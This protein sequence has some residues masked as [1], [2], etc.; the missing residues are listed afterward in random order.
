MA[1]WRKSADKPAAEPAERGGTSP[2]SSSEPTEK[3]AAESGPKTAEK[4]AERPAEKPAE[5]QAEK[6]AEKQAAES[7]PKTAEKPAEKSADKPAEK[8]AEKPAEKPAKKSSAPPAAEAKTGGKS[9][10]ARNAGEVVVAGANA[11]R[12]RIASLLWL[13]AVICA[14]FLAIGALMIALKANKDN[15]IVSFILGGA[16]TL[17]LG[18]FSRKQ[19]IFTFNGSGAAIKNALVNWGIGAVAYL[20]VGKVLDRIIRP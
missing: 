1:R 16:D 9:S 4:T 6:P 11:V 14:L 7:G 12:S 19:G 3:P 5:K 15:A 8:N 17:D 20:L 18:V 10:T 13:L 2:T